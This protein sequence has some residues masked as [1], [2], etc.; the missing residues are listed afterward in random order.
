METKCKDCGKILT[1]KTIK[2]LRDLN[3]KFYG[4]YCEECYEEAE[5]RLKEER[6]VEEYKGQ[7]IYQKDGRYVPYWGCHYWFD[8]IE[9]AR[10]RIDMPNGCAIVDVNVLEAIMRGETY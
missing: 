1:L 10:A 4:V 5:K 9:G 2:G 7:K 3:N 8:C 6:F